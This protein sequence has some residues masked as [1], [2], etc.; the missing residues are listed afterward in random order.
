MFAVILAG[1][2][3]TRLRPETLDRPKPMVEVVGKPILE[4]QIDWIKQSVPKNDKLNVVFCENYRSEVIQKYFGDGSK[5]GINVKHLILPLSLGGVGHL[6]RALQEIPVGEDVFVMAGDV[7]TDLNPQKLLDYHRESES[8][9]TIFTYPYQV[10]LGVINVDKEGRI[11]GFTEKPILLTN[12]AIAIVKS[13]LKSLL[14]EEGGDIFSEIT[15]RLGSGKAKS[16]TNKEAGWW[17]ITT[18]ED[19]NRVREIYS[20]IVEGAITIEFQGSSRKEHL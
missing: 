15:Q 9:L 6:K 8:P 3:G 19:L 1:G 14:P 13:E 5:L 11:Q 17:H 4:R 20:R 12:T 7:L 2:E 10:P 16:Y 18:T